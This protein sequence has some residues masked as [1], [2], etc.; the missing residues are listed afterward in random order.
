MRK[1][2]NHTVPRKL[3]AKIHS[4]KSKDFSIWNSL[5]AEIDEKYE[6]ATN[7]DDYGNHLIREFNIKISNYVKFEPNFNNLFITPYDAG[8][9]F[10]G[11]TFQGYTETTAYNSVN[12]VVLTEASDVIAFQW[13]YNQDQITR[14]KF[15]STLT[16][17]NAGAFGDCELLTSAKIPAS[18]TTIGNG[19]FKQCPALLNIIV[20]SDNPNFTTGTIGSGSPDVGVLFNAAKTKLVMF[21]AGRAGIYAV[22]PTVTNIQDQAFNGCS[23]LT[24]ITITNNTIS[25]IDNAVFQGCNNITAFTVPNGVTSVGENAF[26]GCNKLVTVILPTTGLTTIAFQAFLQCP[27]LTSITIPSTVT[28]IGE[29]AFQDCVLLNTINCNVS[30]T[31]MNATNALLNITASVTINV[32]QNAADW[33]AGADT[34]GGKAVTVVILP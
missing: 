10:L 6:S 34:I 24:S 21:P 31:I 29:S 27:K 19:I 32:P 2:V 33:T 25:I 23:K 11:S 3:Q 20:A 12:A 4:E 1:S 26:R 8:F 22:P 16:T 18:V 5:K 9:R 17:I 13:A 15:K 30:R 14:I 28:S 7:L